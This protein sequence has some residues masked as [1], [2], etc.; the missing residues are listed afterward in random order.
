MNLSI[1]AIADDIKLKALTISSLSGLVTYIIT[2]F[3]KK[4]M[5][6]VPGAIL[7]G[8][9][10]FGVGSLGL[11]LQPHPVFFYVGSKSIFF[12]I[13]LC[14]I[15]FGSYLLISGLVIKLSKQK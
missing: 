4:D 12:P 3:C 15:C 11:F 1:Y 5:R 8:C 2:I 10:V 13:F 7:N 9:W 14:M 6:E